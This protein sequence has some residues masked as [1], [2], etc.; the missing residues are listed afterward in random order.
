MPAFYSPSISKP[1]KKLTVMSRKHIFFWMLLPGSQAAWAQE[2][3]DSTHR[4]LDQVVVTATK[5]PVKQSQTGKVVIVVTHDELEKEA[6]KPLGEVLGE[7]AGITVSGG[8]NDPGTNQSIFIRGAGSGRALITIDGIPVTDPTQ[9]DNSFDINLIPVSMIERIEIS[10]GAQSTLYGSDA[11]A[12]VIN[13]IT[14]KSDIKKPFNG[15][16]SFSGG[17]YG[18]YNG[19]AQVYG[20]VANQLTY[21]VRYNRDHSDGFSQAYDS[22]HGTGSKIPFDHDGYRGDLVAGNLALS[23]V[24]ALTV[25]GFL[26][27][28]HYTA[29]IDGGPFTDA[30]DYTSASK[31]LMAGGGFTYKLASTTLHG[32]YLYSTSDRDLLEDSVFGQTYLSDHYFGKSQFAEMYANTNLG[33]GLTLLNGADY[34]FNS[35]NESGISGTYPLSFKDTSVSQNSLYSSLLYTGSMGLSLELGGRL[36]TD[37]RFGS[38]YTYTFN[39][40]WLI[41]KNWKLYG[42]IASAWKAPT[43]YQLYSAYGDPT[44]QPEKSTNYEGGLQYN[45]DKLNLRATYFHLR[46]KDGIDFNYFTYLYFNYDEEK[47]QGIEWEGSFK[48]NRMVSLSANYTWLKMQEQS[49]SR[50]SYNDTTYGY[51]L[52]VPEHTINFTLGLRPIPAYSRSFSSFYLGITGHYES[53]RYDIGG[54]DAN[55]NPLPDAVLHSF[56][57]LNL[58]AE[59]KPC[60]DLKLFVNGRNITDK[61]FFTLYGY[62]SIPAMWGGGA[63]IEF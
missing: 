62:N 63:T 51:A 40:A 6:G 60:K 44:L 2:V 19:N 56:F 17:N 23:P 33:Y 3:A 8:L 47:G 31:E 26:Q 5:Y 50:V 15:K 37:S 10:K 22:S 42:S 7:Q 11:I 27:Y 53:K 18:T 24:S 9:T 52:R 14:I 49:Q 13:I 32:N 20:K 16:A 28:S 21:N 1:A 41:D 57:I 38:N 35:M 36:N 59:Y 29:D 34:R 45:D 12:G 54:Y 61:K 4:Q 58:Y 39:P 46:T 30:Q 43:L 25:K 48:F 55:F